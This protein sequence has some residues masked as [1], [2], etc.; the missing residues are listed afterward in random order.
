MIVVS[1]MNTEDQEK[2]RPCSGPTRP[3]RVCWTVLDCCDMRVEVR[4]LNGIRTD[5]KTL[6]NR[7]RVGFFHLFFF[8]S[9]RHVPLPKRKGC[10]Y[11]H[12]RLTQLTKCSRNTKRVI[13]S[14]SYDFGLCYIV[15]VGRR[16]MSM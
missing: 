9:P 5:R 15:S 10:F 3:L 16:T 12:L 6:P 4:N 11:L 7:I 1:E 2:D 14:I 8:V 13:L